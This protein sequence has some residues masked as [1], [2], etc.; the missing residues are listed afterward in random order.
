MYKMA[1]VGE[2]DSIFGFATL[3]LDI[4]AVSTPE[5]G[6]R[7]LTKLVKEEYAVIYITEALEEVLHDEILKYQEA[8]LPAIIL[9]PGISGNTGAGVAQVKESVKKAVGSDILFQ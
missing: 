9:I 4:F 2:Y 1:V 3:G 8:A 5:E 6:K 7:I